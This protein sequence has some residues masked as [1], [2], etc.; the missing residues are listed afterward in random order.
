VV[1]AFFAVACGEDG[2]VDVPIR[3]VVRLTGLVALR[4]V[5]VDL[6]YPE[7]GHVELHHLQLV[8]GKD[9]DVLNPWCHGISSS[10]YPFG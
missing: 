9:C 1:D 4:I 8:L 5:L 6:L 10:H 3:E 2:Q 7:G